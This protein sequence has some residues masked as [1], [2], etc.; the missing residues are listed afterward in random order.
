[1]GSPDHGG[2]EVAASAAA[3]DVQRLRANVARA[4]EL[5]YAKGAL[6]LLDVLDARRVLRQTRL[7]LLAARADAA[8][9]AFARSR[10]TSSAAADAATSSPP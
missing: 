10:W 3:E 1:M 7:D 8:R 4:A 6:S 9:A 5:G 2:D